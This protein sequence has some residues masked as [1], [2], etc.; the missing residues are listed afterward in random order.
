MLDVEPFSACLL[1]AHLLGYMLYHHNQQSVTKIMEK[2]AIRPILCF[3]PLLPLNK[4][5]KQ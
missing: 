5:K 2:A 3:Y 4:V 1:I